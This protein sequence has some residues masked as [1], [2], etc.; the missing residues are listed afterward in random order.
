[1]RTQGSS[2]LQVFREA[3][4]PLGKGPCPFLADLKGRSRSWSYPLRDE[5]HGEMREAE[6]TQFLAT[7]GHKRRLRKKRKAY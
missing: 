6:H 7:P 1:M 3:L 4:P 2:I 5:A